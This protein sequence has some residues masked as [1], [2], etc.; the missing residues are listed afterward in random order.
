MASA[1]VVCGASTGSTNGAHADGSRKA[2]KEEIADSRNRKY[3]PSNNDNFVVT[4]SL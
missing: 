3:E 2:P 4:R 1:C